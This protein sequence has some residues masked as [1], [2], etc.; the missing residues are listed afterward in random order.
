MPMRLLDLI[1]TPIPVL[2]SL[3]LDVS[4]GLSS[5]D[6]MGDRHPSEPYTAY[7][8]IYT[9]SG[10]LADSVFL[11]E[12][13][14]RRRRL[15]AISPVT[16]RYVPDQDHLAVVHRIPTR[17]MTW[18]GRRP[19]DPIELPPGDEGYGMFRN[20]VQY[21]FPGGGNGSVIYEAPPGL[22][23][24]K[25]G[26]AA[27]NTLTFTSKIVVSET[28]NTCL[29]L[30]YYS[31]DPHCERIASYT[32]GLFAPTG[33]SVA[34]RTLDLKPFTTALIDVKATMPGE[35]VE[36]FRDP[37]DGL[38]CL[39]YV[40]YSADAV[41]IP[42]ILNL[43]LSGKAVSVEHTHPAQ[44]YTCPSR[45]EHKRLCKHRAVEAWQTRM[46]ADVPV[47]VS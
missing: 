14:T 11:G 1:S 13:P 7:L 39:S 44:T 38:T 17:L 46:P 6:P 30:I 5:E 37:A 15:F 41:L 4:T 21:A 20:L 33:E 8:T 42:L 22:N 9:P 31:L 27:G 32:Y 26:R 10:A 19:E 18:W 43:D 3:G 25:S 2:H 28:V 45:L 12:I 16:K 35:A 29:A 47:A 24:S 23:V 36:R 34:T 40:G